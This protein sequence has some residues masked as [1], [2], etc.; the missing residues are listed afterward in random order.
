MLVES[1]KK[2]APAWKGGEAVPKLCEGMSDSGT[3]E[4]RLVCVWDDS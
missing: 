3:L 4:R 1:Q 2:R